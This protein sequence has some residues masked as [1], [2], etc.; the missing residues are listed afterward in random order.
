MKL[1]VSGGISGIPNARQLFKDGCGM[2]Q[3]A[4][5]ETVNPMEVSACSAEKCNPLN[6]GD[7][8]TPGEYA[9][10]WACYLRYDIISMLACDGVAL[11]ENWQASPGSHFEQYIA[12]RCGLEVRTRT[13]W[14][15]WKKRYDLDYAF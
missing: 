7:S 8:D 2:L 15:D 9:H 4:G 14:I 11:I 10:S 5:F 3:D 12:S 13:E 6:L 1:Y